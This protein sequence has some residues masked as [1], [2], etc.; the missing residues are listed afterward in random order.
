MVMS[1]DA[2]KASCNLIIVYILQK[3]AFQQAMLLFV[4]NKYS[5]KP[6]LPSFPMV[7]FWSYFII[8]P[9]LVCRQVA[10]ILSWAVEDSSFILQTNLNIDNNLIYLDRWSKETLCR[11]TQK[12][13][14]N[15]QHGKDAE[16]LTWSRSVV[17]V[18][19]VM[20][21]DWLFRQR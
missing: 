16:L 3:G 21:R 17:Y 5:N 11:N 10:E 1:K 19:D 14:T 18:S 7:L 2:K 15:Q 8:T 6:S 12:H 9:Q 20:P 13:F 4:Y